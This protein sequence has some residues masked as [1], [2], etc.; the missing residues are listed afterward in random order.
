M[1]AWRA[2]NLS[3]AASSGAASPQASAI[4]SFQTTVA[5]SS[6]LDMAKA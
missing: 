3:P 6:W 4:S 2:A 1:N 5:H